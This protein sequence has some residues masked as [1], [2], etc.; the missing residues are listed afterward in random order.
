MGNTLARKYSGK[1]YTELASA[2]GNIK[3]WAEEASLGHS[4]EELTFS[5]SA[6]VSQPAIGQKRLFDEDGYVASIPA[7]EIL[8][9]VDTWCVCGCTEEDPWEP[10]EEGLDSENAA[11][12]WLRENHQNHPDMTA[13]Y[14][15]REHDDAHAEE[16]FYRC[17]DGSLRYGTGNRGFFAS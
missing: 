16:Y 13:F 15:D 1:G 8:K 7:K 3:K 11:L 14:V 9:Q 4:G 12:A 17:E 6:A 2:C 5:I 10:M